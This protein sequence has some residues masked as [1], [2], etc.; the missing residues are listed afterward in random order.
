MRPGREELPLDYSSRNYLLTGIKEGFH[1][2]NPDELSKLN[3]KVDMD[4]YSSVTH[5]KF[6][7]LA[8][9]QIIEEIEHGHYVLTK[10]TPLITSALGAI[11]KGSSKNAIRLA[12]V[13]T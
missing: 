2:V 1:V 4:N 13:H 10:D 5:G 11:P 6:K 12:C 9:E 8:E 7:R 3:Q